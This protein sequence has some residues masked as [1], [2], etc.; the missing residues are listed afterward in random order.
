MVKLLALG[1]AGS[2]G[3][4]TRYW[5]T[6]FVHRHSKGAFPFGTLLV[7]ILG[8]F[9][10]GLVMYLVNER[11]SFTPETRAVLVVGLVGGFT[12]FST[13]SYETLEL[14]RKGA[15]L[16]AGLNVCGSVLPGVCAVWLGSV[17][18]RVLAS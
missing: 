2:I 7:N 13:F 16:L 14:L 10:I 6:G 5:L 8:C 11:D 9:L 1:L 18:G 4:L 15:P 3:T 17:V 12:T